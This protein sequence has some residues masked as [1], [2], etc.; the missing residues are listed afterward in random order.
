MK[1]PK[2]IYT[3]NQADNSRCAVRE[4]FLNVYKPSDY[5][6]QPKYFFQFA[7][8]LFSITGQSNTEQSEH[9]SKGIK[10]AYALRIIYMELGCSEAFGL[11]TKLCKDVSN[12]GGIPEVIKRLRKLG[13]VRYALGNVELRPGFFQREF[14]PRRYAKSQSVAYWNAINAGLELVT[15]RA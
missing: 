11:A 15:C 10:S 1:A 6:Q 7:T 9:P 8:R 3:Y 12:D 5:N 4:Y 14:V 2:L 13:A